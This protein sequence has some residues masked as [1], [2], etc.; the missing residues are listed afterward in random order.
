M[1]DEKKTYPRLPTKNW[2]TLRDKF[3]QTMPS[4]VDADY[5]Q[6]VLGLTSAASAGN[7][8]GPLRTLGLIDET[9]SPTERAL[10][11]R[12][13]SSYPDVCAAMASDVYPDGL[14]SAIPDPTADYEKAVSWFMRNTGSG[15]GAATGMAGLYS[16]LAAGDVSTR[17][18][19]SAQAVPKAS[20][21]PNG[22]AK[23][24][25]PT[26]APTAAP[27]ASRS[28]VQ[29]P[30]HLAQR[31]AKEAPTL[32]V[33]VQIHISADASADQIEQIFKSMA[34]HLYASA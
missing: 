1:A 4:K 14:R 20:G 21:K 30:M 22:R 2:W 17:V 25:D 3:H 32:N 8:L 24:T 12:E 7:L 19:T 16:L 27:A 11:W 6:S 26:S 31:P 15:R 23:A 29:Q 18:S 10:D 13:D 34:T 33:N 28:T 9:N 5:L